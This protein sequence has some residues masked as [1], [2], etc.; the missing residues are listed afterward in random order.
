ME[1]GVAYGTLPRTSAARSPRPTSRSSGVS[2][3]QLAAP[4]R[5]AEHLV[6]PVRQQRQPLL[7]QPQPRRLRAVRPFQEQ[8]LA[9]L[10]GQAA[11]PL[12]ARRA[13]TARPVHVRLPA[14]GHLRDQPHLRKPLVTAL[15][16]GAA[17]R[18]GPLGLHVRLNL[19][20]RVDRRVERAVALRP[21]HRPRDA[22]MAVPPVPQPLRGQLERQQRPA[23]LPAQARRQHQLH[24]RS[25]ARLGP[26][27]PAPRRHPV[28]AVP[29]QPDIRPQAPGPRGQPRHPGADRVRRPVLGPGHVHRQRQH[30]SPPEQLGERGSLPVPLRPADPHRVLRGPAPPDPV[31]PQVPLGGRPPPR[32]RARTGTSAAAGCPS[33]S[34][35]SSPAQDAGNP[36]TGRNPAGLASTVKS[37]DTNT[38]SPGCKP[39]RA[40]A[41]GR[42]STPST[43]SGGSGPHRPG[44]GTHTTRH[45][46]TNCL[47]RRLNS[48]NHQGSRVAAGR[49]PGRLAAATPAEGQPGPDS[50]INLERRPPRVGWSKPRRARHSCAVSPGA[51]PDFRE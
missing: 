16:L 13:V 26:R 40:T 48:L 38:G 2:S 51:R 32:P 45:S 9:L 31:I 42:S 27:V 41:A 30:P 10:H 22:A 18:P 12:P 35:A 33:R 34:S 19:P 15:L 11:Q 7:R 29:A 36:S 49:P 3:D 39:I 20:E 28:A 5:G 8:V 47:P 1:C 14:P 6:P 17:D 4:V 50:L 21:G 25:I 37:G 23:L 46:P 43:P 24:E 44:S